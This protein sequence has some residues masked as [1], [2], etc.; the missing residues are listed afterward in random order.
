MLDLFLK[1]QESAIYSGR[2]SRLARSVF[3]TRHVGQAIAKK[4]TD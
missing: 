3:S 4:V 2:G 1:E